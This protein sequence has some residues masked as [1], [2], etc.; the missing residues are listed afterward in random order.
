NQSGAARVVFSRVA[1]GVSIFSWAVVFQKAGFVVPEARVEAGEGV[2][3]AARSDVRSRRINR[4]RGKL[5]D[6]RPR[7]RAKR[8]ESEDRRI[9]APLLL[10]IGKLPAGFD[11]LQRN[12][13][14]TVQFRLPARS[15]VTDPCQ[16]IWQGVCPEMPDC[17][18]SLPPLVL[19]RLS[20]I[21]IPFDPA[22][23]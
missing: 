3:C 2:G 7:L 20:G 23:E 6:R 21:G 11:S 10:L 19:R 4:E 18:V 22:T 5:S 17:L 9:P 12:I 14:G 1:A 15:V 16:Q 8:D 13:G